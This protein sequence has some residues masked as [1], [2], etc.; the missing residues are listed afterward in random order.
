MTGATDG[1]GKEFAKQL[2]GMGF[3]VVIIG[4][5]PEA[6]EATSKEIGMQALFILRTL[7]YSCAQLR[8]LVSVA[9]RSMSRLCRLTSASVSTALSDTS[10]MR[11]T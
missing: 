8:P 9:R 5:R 3:N 2:G 1:I 11:L 6:L 10:L 7:T 4:R